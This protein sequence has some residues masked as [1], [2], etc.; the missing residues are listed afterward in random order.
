M[1]KTQLAQ[2][3]CTR[4]SHDIIGNVGAVANAL[5]LFEDGDTDF[6]DD[7]RQI[8]SV[9]SRVL[10]ARM[11]F[12][13]LAFGLNNGALTDND[14][15]FDTIDNYLQTLGSGNNRFSFLS[16]H[17]TLVEHNKMILIAV[18]VLADL[19]PRGGE[20]KTCF[21]GGKLWIAAIAEQYSEQKIEAMKDILAGSPNYDADAQYAH[22]IYLKELVSDEYRLS[23]MDAQGP[24][25]VI[26]KK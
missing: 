10:S 25:L 19:L 22:I 14:V 9:S 15:V 17:N 7:I 13:R 12:F 4:I 26:S 18:M 8:L 3:V 24:V 11:R 20:I 16:D 21:E 5:E 2:L 6:F 1:E 23:L